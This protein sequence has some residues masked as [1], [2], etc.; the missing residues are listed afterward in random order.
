MDIAERLL[1]GAVG[2]AVIGLVVI[3]IRAAIR[4]WLKL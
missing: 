1:T 3:G 4:R 2:G